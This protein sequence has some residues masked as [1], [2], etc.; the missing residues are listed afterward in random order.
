MQ[1]LKWGCQSIFGQN[2][3]LDTIKS[4]KEESC[5]TKFAGWVIDF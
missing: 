1:L 4:A 2:E 3:R 5:A